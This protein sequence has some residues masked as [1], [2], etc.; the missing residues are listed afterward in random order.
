MQQARLRGAITNLGPL[1]VVLYCWVQGDELTG[2]AAAIWLAGGL[3]LSVSAGGLLLA[4]YPSLGRILASIGLVGLLGEAAIPLSQSPALALASALLVWGL[5][6]VL[7]TRPA[8]RTVGALDGDREAGAS[9]Q[10]VTLRTACALSLLVWF[11][12]VRVA[13]SSGPLVWAALALSLALCLLLALSWLALSRPLPGR[14]V[15]FFGASLA[16]LV[17]GLLL[18]WGNWGAALRYSAFVPLSLG[19][20]SRFK[21]RKTDSIAGQWLGPF[22]ANP[23]RV[24]VLTFLVL[25]AGGSL[26]L[27]L[28]QS[29]TDPEGISLVDA[30]FTSVS[31][32]CVTGLIVRDTP[33]DFT[34]FGQA[35]ILLLIQLGGLGIMTFSLAILRVMGSR[36][37][38]R[39]EGTMAGLVSGEDRGRLLQA[40]SRM[41]AVTFIAE[42]AGATI[43]TGLFWGEGDGWLQGLWRGIF[44]AVSAFCNAGFALQ[45]DSLMGYQQNALILQVVALLIIVGGISPLVLVTFPKFMRRETMPLENRIVFSATAI[46]LVLGTLIIVAAEWSNTLIGLSFWD[47]LNNA[48]FQSVTLRTAGF[49]S[50][51]V[52]QIRAATFS[53]MVVWMFIGG[54]PGGTAGG[55][56]T[57]TTAVLVLSVV[58]TMRGRWQAAAFGRAIPHRAVYKAA[59]VV[60]VGAAS[61]G[62]GVLAIQLTQR[63]SGSA[64]FFEV[65][66]ALGT[67]G[68]SVGGTAGLDDVGKIIIMLCMF[69]GRVGPLTLF[70]FLSDRS[71]R[72]FWE[73]AEEDIEV[74]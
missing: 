14:H 72:S 53:L 27:F 22:L 25:C 64:G 34:A 60:T 19:W 50:V 3:G 66:S 10:S 15:L 7:W 74:G 54:S 68:L 23:A 71:A 20:M 40:L 59:A 47:R 4:S 11:L 67:V 12:V 49:N 9:A 51:D 56:K 44:T 63:L 28:P 30:A 29:G 70:V 43:L 2:N 13:L 65:V 39:H 1:L 18:D 38:I 55:V 52:S 57:T 37:S 32:V 48:W 5:L 35:M 62:L 6:V 73:L 69:V 61:V 26:L 45:S 46:L 33:V 41:V 17:G 31:A 58:A 36:L 16:I 21:V 8:D 42:A 24:L